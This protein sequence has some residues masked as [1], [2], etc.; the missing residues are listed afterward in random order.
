MFAHTL[1]HFTFTALLKDG[2]YYLISSMQK[3]KCTSLLE[4]TFIKRGLEFNPVWLPPHFPTVFPQT[5][6]V[7]STFLGHRSIFSHSF[8]AVSNDKFANFWVF[9]ILLNV[10]Q[11]RHTAWCICFDICSFV[12]IIYDNTKCRLVSYPGISCQSNNAWEK[13]LNHWPLKSLQ[14]REQNHGRDSCGKSSIVGPISQVMI[15]N[16]VFWNVQW[17]KSFLLHE[18][19]Q[20]RSLAK[21]ETRG[22]ST[23]KH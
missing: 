2:Y 13:S 7:Y 9:L 19:N 18:A 20:Q 3:P 14:R 8:R 17:C 15:L 16:A 6:A 4:G 12:L 21:E 22:M 10:Q 5:T 11:N 1:S 23:R